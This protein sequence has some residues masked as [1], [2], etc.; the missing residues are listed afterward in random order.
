MQ[1]IQI[2]I[3]KDNP[4]LKAAEEELKTLKHW[5]VS[6]NHVF[7]TKSQYDRMD[8]AERSVS[9]DFGRHEMGR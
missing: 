2:I 9:S 6:D 8:A 4:D 7:V 3:V 1:L 5:I